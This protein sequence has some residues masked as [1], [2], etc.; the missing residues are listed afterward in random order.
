MSKIGRIPVVIPTGV[1]VT[2]TGNTLEA[3]GPKG[4]ITYVIPAG[5]TVKVDGDKIQVTNT[6]EAGE[7][8]SVLQGLVRASIA[9][10][11]KGVE[12]GFEKKLELSGVGYRASI[13]GK[14]ITLSV[15]FSHQVKVT[16]PEGITY[17]IHEN[18]ISVSGTNKQ[19]VGDI[20]A[21][22]RAIRP[23]EP[24]K[25][26]GIRYVGEVVRRKAGKAA[27]LIGGVK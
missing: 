1:T 20:A 21:K 8:A 9:N 4:T 5:T 22:I 16:A 27:K 10:L 13:L 6:K 26:K 17:S 18:I 15:G 19:L 7:N 2:I 14:D 3:V 24:Y 11:V 12:T 25:G 23:P